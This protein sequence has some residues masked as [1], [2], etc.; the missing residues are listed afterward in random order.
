MKKNKPKLLKIGSVISGTTNSHHLLGAFH[1]TLSRLHLTSDDW[2]SKC[3]IGGRFHSDYEADRKSGAR[4]GA[5]LDADGTIEELRRE[6]VDRL[7]ALL[8]AYCPDYCYFG[9]R[10]G[11]GADFG[12]WP[13]HEV[14]FHGGQTEY[15][16]K[17]EV[18]PPA[19]SVD[20]SHFLLVNDH[21]NAA[22]Y[23]KQRNGRNWRWAKCWEV[24]WS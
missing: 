20:H 11:D 5:D 23:R 21:G 7:I 18:L 12:C 3:I 13:G 16:A 22:L 10:D 15:I 14:P 8:N 19:R 1:G 6:D 24:V 9:A 4:K 17:G 2:V